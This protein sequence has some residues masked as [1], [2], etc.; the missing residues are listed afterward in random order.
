[1]TKN[2]QCQTNNEQCSRKKVITINPNK[3]MNINNHEDRVQLAAQTLEICKDGNYINTKGEIISINEE[4]NS[5]L[6]KTIFYRSEELD[7]LLTEST[8]SNY[9]ET[10]FEV[11]GETT[12]EAAAR[13]L[14]ENNNEKIVA[15]NFASAKNAGGGFLRGSVAQEESIARSSALYPS[16]L[17]APDYYS[18]HR[19]NPNLLYTDNMIYSPGVPVFRDDDGT[20]LDQPYLLSVITSP[21][22]NKGAIIQNK[23]SGLDQ[24]EEV[25]HLR[26]EKVLAL[27]N[28]HGHRV[29]ILGA[30]G[31]GVFG[32]DPNLI[33]EIFR[34]HLCENPR[35]KN[36]FERVVFAVYDRTKDKGVITPFREVY[37]PD[38]GTN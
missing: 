27:A 37:L 5:C 23:V 14:G 32:N 21:A 22:A 18:T 4:L 26:T 33:A 16:L 1:M 11:T 8:S 38:F 12:L 19:N 2:V 35:F 28:K 25:M 31:C 36:V 15:L 6:E 10:K 9:P 20:L 34:F 30:W 13:L 3:K 17:K 24:I 7:K 29:L